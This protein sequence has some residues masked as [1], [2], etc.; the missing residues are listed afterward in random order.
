MGKLCDEGLILMRDTSL[1][2]ERDNG[3]ANMELRVY[4]FGFLALIYIE[5][6][7]R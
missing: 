5:M 7:M 6:K 2:Q 3:A 1:I 4:R